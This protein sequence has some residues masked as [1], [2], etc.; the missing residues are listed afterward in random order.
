MGVIG[1]HSGSLNDHLGSSLPRIVSNEGVFKGELIQGGQGSGLT[2]EEVSK[3][4]RHQK[5]GQC[6]SVFGAPNRRAP[7]AHRCWA[8]LRRRLQRLCHP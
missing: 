8:L 3:I 2:S 5:P 6:R 7:G 1:V 4:D